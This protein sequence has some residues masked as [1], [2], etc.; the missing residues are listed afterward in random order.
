MHQSWERQ[1]CVTPELKI[2][3]TGEERGQGRNEGLA[4]GWESTGEQGLECE[5]LPQI[6]ES[7]QP[8]EALLASILST[9]RLQEMSISVICV[10][11]CASVW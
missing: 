3:H 6:K 10:C 11:L 2:D 8:P 1:T 5:L 9:E 7:K 4:L